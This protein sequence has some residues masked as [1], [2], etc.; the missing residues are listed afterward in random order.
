M[1][2]EERVRKVR[3]E[4]FSRALHEYGCD[5][6]PANFE[7]YEI[8][9]IIYGTMGDPNILEGIM[10]RDVKVEMIGLPL[11]LRRGRKLVPLL[12][13]GDYMAK[14]CSHR[15]RLPDRIIEK[16]LY[17]R[18]VTVKET[19]NFRKGL[20]VDRHSDFVAFITL[21][22]RKKGTEIIPD[23]DIGWYL[24]AGG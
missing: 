19:Y 14:S 3:T 18:T 9:D 22:S 20:L 15:V 12:A 16:I 7:L 5:R 2:A 11:L 13:L 23:L 17:G 8:G 24:R 21:R 4:Q 6:F 10:R 1:S